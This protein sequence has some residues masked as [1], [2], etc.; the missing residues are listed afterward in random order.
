[1]P[2]HVLAIARS[3]ISAIHVGNAGHTLSKH[4]NLNPLLNGSGR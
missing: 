2:V 4:S 1:M 3:F